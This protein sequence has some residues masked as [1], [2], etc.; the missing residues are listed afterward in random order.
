[1]N[2]T[3]HCERHLSWRFWFKC[4]GVWWQR[5]WWW[6]WDSSKL[7]PFTPVEAFYHFCPKRWLTRL[8][9]SD[10]LK[11]SLPVQFSFSE[12]FSPSQSLPATTY[13]HQRHQQ[14]Q[15]GHEK[16]LEVAVVTKG[17]DQAQELDLQGNFRGALATS[18]MP[19]KWERLKKSTQGECINEYVWLHLEALS[20]ACHHLTAI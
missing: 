17:V 8:A 19:W 2:Q 9:V 7:F 14:H 5:R 11:P 16:M 6:G 3:N 4:L 18:I 1:M 20:F 10:Y 13:Q 12:N 15:P